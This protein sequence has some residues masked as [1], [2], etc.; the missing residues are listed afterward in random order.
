LSRPRLRR[1]TREQWAK[2]GI[3]AQLLAVL[4]LLGEYFR[5]KQVHG[6]QLTIALVEPFVTGALLAAVLCSVGVTLFFFRRFAAAIVV[7]LATVALLLLYKTVAI[8][9]P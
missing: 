7:A 6:S 3:A 5:L 8:G 9:W 2:L 4:R 1:L